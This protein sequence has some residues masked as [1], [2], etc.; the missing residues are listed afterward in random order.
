[1]GRF[2]ATPLSPVLEQESRENENVSTGFKLERPP[3]NRAEMKEMRDLKNSKI[4]GPL[5]SGGGVFFDHIHTPWPKPP[6]PR[7][8]SQSVSF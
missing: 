2:Q 3:S 7:P 8:N 5:P 4:P 1:M 6:P